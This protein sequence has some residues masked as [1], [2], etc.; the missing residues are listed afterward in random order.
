MIVII[1]L[2]I[3]LTLANQRLQNVEIL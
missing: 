3:R 1:N 2:V